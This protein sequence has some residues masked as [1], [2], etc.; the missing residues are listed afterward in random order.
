MYLDLLSSS[1]LFLMEIEEHGEFEG[2]FVYLCNLSNGKFNWHI[3]RAR[4]VDLRQGKNDRIKVQLFKSSLISIKRENLQ[5]F[6][7]STRTLCYGSFSPENVKSSLRQFVKIDHLL[8]CII[9]YLSVHLGTRGDCIRVTSVG[10]SESSLTYDF[11]EKSALEEGTDTCW[12]SNDLGTQ[13]FTNAWLAF[14]FGSVIRVK[15]F[16]VRIPQLPG[17]PLAVRKFYL[18]A[19][20]DGESWEKASSVFTTHDTNYIQ[21]FCVQPAIE[22]QHIRM[23]CITTANPMAN[24]VGLWEVQFNTAT[25]SLED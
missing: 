7:L 22:A 4:G 10:T 23:R 5:P 24:K 1:P 21:K 16:A 11:S 14:E 13:P 9:D 6:Q 2:G 17:G 18:E 3:A 15:S 25:M 12:I 19:C 8:E 20:M